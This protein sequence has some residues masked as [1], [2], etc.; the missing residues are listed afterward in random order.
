MGFH[1]DE[2][3]GGAGVRRMWMVGSEVGGGVGWWGFVRY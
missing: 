1:G 3:V 2:V